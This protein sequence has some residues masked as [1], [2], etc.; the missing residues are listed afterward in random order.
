M[1]ADPLKRFSNRVDNYV[2]YRPSY[3]PAVVEYLTKKC[4]LNEDSA[5]AD[6]G[7]GTGIFS[8]LLLE[9]RFNVYGVE[10]NDAM[11]KRAEHD[12]KQYKKFAS[13]NGT[14]ENTTLPAD[15]ID[16]IVCAQAFHWFCNTET[17]KEFKRIL[18][19]QSCAAL[20]W[21]N[22]QT[23]ADA[24]AT[25]YEL[26]L[27]EKS[28]DYSEV[29]HKNLTETDFVSFFKDGKYET[30]K[31]PNVQVF[32]FDALRGRAFSSSYVPPEDTEEGQLFLSA[33][34]D[35][36]DQYRVKGKVKFTYQTEVYLGEV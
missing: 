5:V 27:K 18:K 24:F 20:L 13:V 1:K 10:P 17:R 28:P 26:L 22:R 29:N 32:D 4:S 6:I 12:L 7:S 25:A 23:D 16:L 31:Y 30:A 11:R 9:H 34:H 14:A 36:F 15:C 2:K 8:K 35:I 19:P 21:N 3:P 33:L